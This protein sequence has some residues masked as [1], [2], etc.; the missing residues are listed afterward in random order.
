M[1][2][3]ARHTRCRITGSDV[4]R[5]S[6][7]RGLCN[8]AVD[9]LLYGQ[10]SPLYLCAHERLDFV[11]G[12]ARNEAPIKRMIAKAD[13]LLPFA[14]IAGGFACESKPDPA[15]TVN[16]DA[17]LMVDCLRDAGINELLKGY[18]SLARSVYQ[19]A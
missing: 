4:V 5:T 3:H 12:D 13:V 10:N 15:R 17:P 14:R 11:Q 1:S 7:G 9:N 18:K 8:H 16:L 19:N 2:K 6:A